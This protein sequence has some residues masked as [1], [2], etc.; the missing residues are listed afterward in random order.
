M[1]KKLIAKVQKLTAKIPDKSPEFSN[2]FVMEPEDSSLLERYGTLYVVYEVDGGVDLDTLLVTKL[3]HDVLY[4][5]YF[6]SENSSPIQSLE[7]SVLNLKDKLTGF[8][9]EQQALEVS[10]SIIVAVLWGN[11]LYIVQ[12]GSGNSYLMRE[13]ELKTI[14][15]AS[16]GNFS[17]ASGVVK[18][19]DVVILGTK[20]FLTKHPVATL[21]S[22]AATISVNALPYGASA[23]IL[24]FTVDTTFSKD[25]VL[26]IKSDIERPYISSSASAKSFNVPSAGIAGKLGVALAKLKS[27]GKLMPRGSVKKLGFGVL[28]ILLLG[29]VAYTLKT[30]FA[31]K[32][33][34]LPKPPIVSK[35]DVEGASSVALDSTPVDTSADVANKIQRITPELFYDLKLADTNANPSSIIALADTLVV[36][37]FSKGAVYSSD[38]A[39]PKFNQAKASYTG[40]KQ[41]FAYGSSLGV[42]DST[43]LSLVDLAAEDPSTTQIFEGVFGKI[44]V[45]LDFLYSLNTSDG[46]VTKYTL[47]DKALTNALWGTFPEL[48]SAIS[49]SIN[50]SIYVLDANSVLQVYTQGEKDAFEIKGL[51]VPL[52]NASQV[53][54]SENLDNI[55]IADKGNNR[56]VVLDDEGNLLKQFQAADRTYFNDIRSIVVNAAEDALFV[57]DG[58]KV[59]QIKL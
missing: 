37:D 30:G 43:G 6:H 18:D 44:A 32:D 42:V 26:D 48:V 19:D 24:K 58:S 20:S 7:K 21:V 16:E 41:I 57:L 53:F 4:D 56:I 3:V 14:N 13:G 40:L 50:V 28:G 59:Y 1:N 33:K 52:R 27:S 17:V 5:T 38:V 31:G 2:A 39:V 10:I 22:S 15:A 36:A 23:L 55:Y 8:Y 29:L 34:E 46:V 35:K 45:Y 54:T 47:E 25:E 49:H 9:H 51:S 12:F 11:V